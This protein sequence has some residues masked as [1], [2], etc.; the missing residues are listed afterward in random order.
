[1]SRII[2][3]AS[4]P[5]RTYIDQNFGSL[6]FADLLEIET[7][8]G[9]MYGWCRSTVQEYNPSKPV[10][11]L[12]SD[13]VSGQISLQK[14]RIVHIYRQESIFGLTNCISRSTFSAQPPWQILPPLSQ[15]LAAK[16]VF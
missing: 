3:L 16:K 4:L 8:V 10:L 11:A 13:G 7:P 15:M 12:I 6:I 1:M 14:H 9:S 2:R 5:L